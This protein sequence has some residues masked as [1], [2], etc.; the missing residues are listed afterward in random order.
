[1]KK[2]NIKGTIPIAYTYLIVDKLGKILLAGKVRESYL[3]AVKASFS[4]NL[5]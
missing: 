1:M 5:N 2:D 3:I 4:W